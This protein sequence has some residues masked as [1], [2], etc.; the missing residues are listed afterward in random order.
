MNLQKKAKDKVDQQTD[1]FGT[2]K[3]QSHG[4]RSQTT[5]H[6]FRI[7]TGNGK[8]ISLRNSAEKT[9]S[10][11]ISKKTPKTSINLILIISAVKD[12]S[13]ESKSGNNVATMNIDD[14]LKDLSSAEVMRRNG[15]KIVETKNHRQRWYGFNRTC[16]RGN[17]WYGFNYGYSVG[18]AR[19]KFQGTG[20]AKLSYG[21][22]Y[23]LGEVI[24]YLNNVE[25]SRASASNSKEEVSFDYKR[26]DELSINETMGII[27]LN[28]LELTAL[29]PE[30][31]KTSTTK[32]NVSQETFTG[33]DISIQEYDS[34]I[35]N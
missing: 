33:I 16:G 18:S 13:I 3:F 22:C 2:T 15:W 10:L 21:N 19:A 17:T 29:K 25:I 6:G 24:V 23:H 27:K 4:F 34:L 31:K 14:K 9:M 35:C 32:E 20:R 30:N 11:S 12:T 8:L 1:E 7:F 28:S 5:H 26:N